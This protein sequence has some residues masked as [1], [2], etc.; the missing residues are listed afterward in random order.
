MDIWRN[1]I[2]RRMMLFLDVIVAGEQTSIWKLSEP[3]EKNIIVNGVWLSTIY[4][5]V[6]VDN[7]VRSVNANI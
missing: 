4:A 1:G 7:L 3:L 6:E 2:L 5:I